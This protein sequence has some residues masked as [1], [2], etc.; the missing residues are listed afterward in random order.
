MNK[1]PYP[2]A[3]FQSIGS[4]IGGSIG[5]FIPEL[6]DYTTDSVIVGR[7]PLSNTSNFSSPLESA[8]GDWPTIAVGQPE[9]GPVGTGLYFNDIHIDINNTEI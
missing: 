4:R 7:L 5:R 3:D 8:D 9:I 2:Q 1:G 6:A